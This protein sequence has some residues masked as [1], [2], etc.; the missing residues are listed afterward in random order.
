MITSDPADAQQLLDAL[1]GLDQFTGFPTGL[2]V[3]CI[4]VMNSVAAPAFPGALVPS[5]GSAGEMQVNVA[6]PTVGDW[7]RLKPILLAFAGPTI[8]GF[9]GIPADFSSGDAAGQILM[10][11]A[12]A[13]TATMPL[14]DDDKSRLMALRALTRARATLERAPDLQRSAP[15]PTS[16]LLASFQDHLNVRRRDA[17]ARILERLTTELRLDALNLNFLAV[18]F[19]ATF[20]DW[21]AIL[22]IPQF[23]SLCRARRTS[24]V[25]ALLLE[26][27]YQVNLAALFEAADRDGL[28]ARYS[29][30]VRPLAQGMLTVPP[31]SAL[32]H[33]GA[34]IYALEALITNSGADL[35]TA[36]AADTAKLD[37]LSHHFA[38]APEVEA[39]PSTET[40]IDA[41]REKLLEAD[42]ADDT[43]R[44]SAALQALAK[45]SSEELE[46]L[47]G[48]I[49][50]APIVASIEPLAEIDLP[51]S[52][53]EWLSR[54][55]DPAFETALDIARRGAA[56]WPIDMTTTS[57]PV[58][59]QALV[60][61]IDEAQQSAL[62]ADR[63]ALALPYLV[64]WLQRD[65]AFPRP[66]LEPVY[67]SL[68]TLFALGNARGASIYDSSQILITALLAS[69]LDQKS[70]GAL[71]ADVLEIAGDGYGVNMV[72]WLLE[73]VEAFMHAATPDAEARE[74]FL[75]GIL[76]R[77]TPLLARLTGLQRVAVELLGAELGWSFDALSVPR[78]TTETDGLAAH[79]AGLRIAIYSL[80]ESSSRQA[81]A[82]L[83]TL[84]P[85]ATI[86]TNA[87]HGGT[88]RLRALSEN[89]DLFVMTW[90]SAKHAA[91]D[92]IRE[93]RGDRP[94]LYAQG[95]G[96][97]SIL[98]VI[99][100]HLLRPT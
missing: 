61:A 96:F 39:G 14:P 64:A 23:P 93:H 85:T 45:L 76:A 18:Q 86:D 28:I 43:N 70:Y 84:A 2:Q 77:I 12:P 38:P 69:G 67:S 31:P 47:R 37:W 53:L 44:V 51:S 90:L 89:A 1:M 17:A 4:E 55:A 7:R 62:A 36:I 29:A 41:A 97:S 15:A 81:K 66:A 95:K 16:W 57:D 25:T 42:A 34:R 72:Y 32:T 8:T 79:L 26:A 5:V 48:A 49:P 40:P 71:I 80:T 82:A 50:F 20:G 56:E 6:T 46:H 83:E 9:T 73:I 60:A 68:L 74:A 59:V 75:H 52:W 54:A 30:D 88:A 65:E 91:T 94:L 100:D 11:A 13:V 78:A 21:P 92:F 19:F 33:G 10:S 63:T 98:R 22:A 35:P 27:L 99:E 3:L 87:D 58:A 24:T